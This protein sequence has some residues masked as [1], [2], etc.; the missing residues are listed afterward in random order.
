MRAKVVIDGAE[1]ELV[2]ISI[3]GA[4]VRFP[5][6]LAPTA[7][8]VELILPGAAPV[9][10]TVV[11]TVRAPSSLDQIVSMK[12]VHD[13][14]AAFH[15]ISMWLFHTPPGAIDGIPAGVPAVA[16]MRRRRTARSLGVLIAE[17][18]PAENV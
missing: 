16:A 9:R 13:D 10:L 1:G 11:R 4:A 12:V 8:V 3:G 18:S 5:G 15:A 2:D 14:W 7:Q 6:G 17:H